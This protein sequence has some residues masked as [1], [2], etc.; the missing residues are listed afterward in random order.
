MIG[1]MLV[2]ICLDLV[3]SVDYDTLDL[4]VISDQLPEGKLNPPLEFG[5]RV[6]TK[7]STVWAGSI[8]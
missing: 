1:I 3:S 5:I 8:S 4:L 6:A 2:Q 7:R